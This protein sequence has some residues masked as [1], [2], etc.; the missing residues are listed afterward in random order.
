MI[1]LVDRSLWIPAW[2]LSSNN[3]PGDWEGAARA[4][5]PTNP[6]ALIF[7]KAAEDDWTSPSLHMQR[8]G[9][10]A[11]GFKWV[12]PYDFAR[13]DLV[14]GAVE[15]TR[16]IAVIGADGGLL[17]NEGG[18][19]DLEVL[20]QHPELA[21]ADLRAYV[22]DWFGIWHRATGLPLILYS[23]VDQLRNFHMFETPTPLDDP[24]IYLW[25]VSL[26]GTIPQVPRGQVVMIQDNWHG[27][28]PGFAGDVDHSWWMGSVDLLRSLTWGNQPDPLAGQRIVG[29]ADLDP[30]TDLPTI[31]HHVSDLL[32]A[33]TLD[34]P[35]I[36][37]DIALART[38]F[39]LVV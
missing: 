3:P 23:A 6:N 20:S 27:A 8:M 1:Q 4:V 2:D 32:S 19:L 25:L 21:T 12:F 10:H 31:L 29:T 22:S 37:A 5:L 39:G 18:A 34:V 11:A 35:T 17:L 24:N 26:D 36:R 28:L 15:A 9:A 16:F 7:P 14:S 30:G 38:K 13:Y 33:P